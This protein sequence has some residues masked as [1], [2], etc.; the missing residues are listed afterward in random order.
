MID[1]TLLEQLNAE[2]RNVAIR[3]DAWN[4]K[5]DS[6]RFLFYLK[7]LSILTF[8]FVACYTLYTFRFQKPTVKI[9]ESSLYSPQYK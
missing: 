5:V 1:K 7:G 9:N 3:S 2:N 4:N 8:I 6:S